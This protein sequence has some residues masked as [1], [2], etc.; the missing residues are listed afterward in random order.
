MSASDLGM[1][2]IRLL[3]RV[4]NQ[5]LVLKLDAEDVAQWFELGGFDG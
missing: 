1:E 4:G 5:R 2:I 3:R